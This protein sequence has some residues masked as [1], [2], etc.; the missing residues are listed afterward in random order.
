M[1]LVVL[2]PAVIGIACLVGAFALLS[3]KRD[4]ETGRSAVIWVAVS[5]L[6]LCAF[7]IGGCYAIVWSGGL[8]P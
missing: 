6:F 3:R 5:L 7:G 4:E 2:G 1:L 8:K